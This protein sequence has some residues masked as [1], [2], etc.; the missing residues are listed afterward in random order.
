MLNTPTDLRCGQQ[1]IRDATQLLERVGTRLTQSK[2]LIQR[3][4][5]CTVAR[6]TKR[7]FY[8]RQD[9]FWLQTVVGL[10]T[11]KP[12]Q[13]LPHGLGQRGGRRH[14]GLPS[15]VLLHGG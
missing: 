2:A 3:G 11:E 8:R 12:L 7:A 14:D 6:P 10:L 15:T 1:G 9:V 4:K 13:C 5:A